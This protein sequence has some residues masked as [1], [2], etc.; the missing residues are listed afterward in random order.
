MLPTQTIRTIVNVFVIFSKSKK[1][2]QHI[3]D[4][5]IS[6][7]MIR[8]EFKIYIEQLR[9]HSFSLI[10]KEFDIFILNTLGIS[11]GFIF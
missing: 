1:D 5:F 3:Y 11:M 6:S 8:K 10:I 2:L 4:D 7:D 9:A